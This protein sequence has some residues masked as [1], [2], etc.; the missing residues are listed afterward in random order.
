MRNSTKST[1][2]ALSSSLESTN[3]LLH[4]RGQL[5]VDSESRRKF[6][7][8][9]LVAFS[10]PN[11]VI[12]KGRSHGARHGKTEEQKE[13]HVDWNAWKGCFKKVDSQGGHCTGLHDRFLRDPRLSRITIRNRMDRRGVCQEVDELTKQKHTYYLSTE[14]FQKI[15]RRMVSRLEKVWQKWTDAISTRFSSCRHT[16]KTFPPRV[17]CASCRANFSTTI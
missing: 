3:C 4:L 5:V 15:P 10:I 1:L 2:F 6:H 9:R 12:K 16:Q 17:R 13:Y 11:Y 7:K 8:Q 14:E